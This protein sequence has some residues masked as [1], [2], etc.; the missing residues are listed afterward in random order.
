MWP[1]GPRGEELPEDSPKKKNGYPKLRM[2]NGNEVVDEEVTAEDQTHL[3]KDYTRCAVDFIDRHAKEPFFLYV[4][5]SMVHVPLYVSP[6]FE[7]KS[8]AGLFGDAVME[9][10]WSVGEILAVLKAE[11]ARRKDDR[12]FHR[13]QRSVA[14]LRRPRRFRACICCARGRERCLKGGT[15]SPA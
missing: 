7:G 5:H 2:F 4:P 15:A 10:D 13:R 9:L 12:H 11:R 6:D 14:Q 8:G 1:Q 3:T